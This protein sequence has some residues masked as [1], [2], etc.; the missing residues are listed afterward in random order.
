MKKFIKTIIA[1]LAT[2]VLS[3][4]INFVYSLFS[5][6]VGSFSMFS[7]WIWLICFGAVFCGIS[8]LVFLYKKA[9]PSRLSA[10]IYHSG[11]SVFTVG[12]LIRGVLE[13]AGTSSPLV[14]VYNI[15]GISLIAIGTIFA[16][17]K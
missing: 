6:G 15:A 2:A 10:N 12:L 5:H 13:I 7:M 11:V 14:V 8:Q 1:Y 17:F 3:F 4:V 16:F 9:L